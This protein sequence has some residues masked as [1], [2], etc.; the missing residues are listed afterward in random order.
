[1]SERS[2]EDLIQDETRRRLF[3]E[4]GRQCVLAEYAEQ[5]T[6]QKMLDELDGLG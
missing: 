2:D 5:I 1:M 3:G 6:A 4:N